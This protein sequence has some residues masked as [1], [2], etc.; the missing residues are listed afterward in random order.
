MLRKTIKNMLISGFVAVFSVSAMA[1]RLTFSVAPEVP[2]ALID[3]VMPRFSLKTRVRFER[4]DADGIVQFVAGSSA[5]TPIFELL[6]GAIPVSLVV[7]AGYQDTADVEAFRTWLLS[8]PG[9]AAIGDFT[10]DG[11]AVAA[12]AAKQQAAAIQ[13]A[14]VGDVEVGRDLSLSHCTRCHKVDRADKYSGLDNSPSFHAM[15]SFDDWYVRFSRFYAV[16]PHKA[17]IIVEGSGI[18]KDESLISM[19]PI[20]LSVN[21]V[22]DIVAF[23][24]SL[25]PLDLGQPIQSNP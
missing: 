25:E 6:D 11:V 7:D 13:I 1:E 20:R 15:R 12:P 22:N 19:Q 18:T 4:V 16:S 17:L 14:I 10:M 24:H 9:R 5:G 3:Y 2:A 8:E 23:V 21:E